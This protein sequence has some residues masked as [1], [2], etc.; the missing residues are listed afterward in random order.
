MIRRPP[1]STL[2]PY[3]TLFRSG[4]VTKSADPFSFNGWEVFVTNGQLRAAYCVSPIRL[5]GGPDGLHGPFI[6]DGTWHY[7]A[8]VVDTNGGRLH[9][10]GFLAANGP[11]AGAP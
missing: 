3:T 11:W 1:R 6:A 7:I 8:F 5:V 9:A 2:F 10:D 4:L